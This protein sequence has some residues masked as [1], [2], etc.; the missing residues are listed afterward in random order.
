MFLIRPIEFGKN[1]MPVRFRRVLHS[2]WARPRNLAFLGASL[3]ALAAGCGDSKPTSIAPPGMDASVDVENTP[4]INGDAL[5]QS[6]EASDE[7]PIDDLPDVPLADPTDGPPTDEITD[8]PPDGDSPEM[9]A[10]VADGP[11]DAPEP[12][13]EVHADG[14]GDTFTPGPALQLWLRGDRNVDCVPQGISNRVTTWHDLSGHGRDARPATGKVGPL[15]GPSANQLNGNRAVTF[16]RTPDME[17]EEHLE[18]DLGALIGSAFTVAIV[19]QRTGTQPLRYMLGSKVPFPDS[20]NCGLN[21]NVSKGILF[22]YRMAGRLVAS[23]WGRNCDLSYILPPIADAP[24]ASFFIYSPA[25]GLSLFVDGVLQANQPGMGIDQISGLIGRGF[26]LSSEAPDSRYHGDL[27]ELMVFNTAITDD[28]RQQLE[29][30]FRAS[31]NT[32]P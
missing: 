13:A 3:L 10:E 23:T 11:D 16:P 6:P 7:V 1:R 20:I 25:A 29:T 31:W 4:V 2:S 32:L 18:V 8:L 22:G 17:G 5:D 28:Q 26:E 9:I 27:A 12:E 21:P 14:T 30:Y 15:C 24:S 19:E